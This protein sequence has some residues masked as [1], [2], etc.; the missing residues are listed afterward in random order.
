MDD[1]DENHVTKSK[2]PTPI[3]EVRV[4]D[5]QG[6]WQFF[7]VFRENIGE[8]P[9]KVDGRD[10]NIARYFRT[11]LACFWPK[12]FCK[13]WASQVFWHILLIFF[14]PNF[15]EICLKIGEIWL[16]IRE[17]FTPIS[18]VFVEFFERSLKLFFSIFKTIFL[19]DDLCEEPKMPSKGF[20]LWME[21]TKKQEGDALKATLPNMGRRWRKKS[22]GSRKQWSSTS[23]V[24]HKQYKRDMDIWRKKV[25]YDNLKTPFQLY[26]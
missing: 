9:K 26:F 23:K 25:K 7:C 14:L 3:P 1:A 6:K 10:R 15:G 19:V 21:H 18:F 16:K 24:L 22:E 4:P 20:F 2:T 12:M 5:D 11:F 13:K 8:F 17:I